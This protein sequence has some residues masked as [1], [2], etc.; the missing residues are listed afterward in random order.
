MR[1]STLCSFLRSVRLR[2]KWLLVRVLQSLIRN[3]SLFKPKARFFEDLVDDLE[4]A[5]A[6]SVVVI[7]WAF[8][9]AK[10]ILKTLERVLSNVNHSLCLLCNSTYD[11]NNKG[12]SLQSLYHQGHEGA[13]QSDFTRNYLLPSGFCFF[14]VF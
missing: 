10:S 1:E 12:K 2:I 8:P 13:V 9:W 3:C 14:S 11:G 4:Q 7:Q 5:F 6:Q